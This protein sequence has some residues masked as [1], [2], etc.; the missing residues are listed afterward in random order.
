MIDHVFLQVKNISNGSSGYFTQCSV[1]NCSKCAWKIPGLTILCWF[2][3]EEEDDHDDDDDKQKQTQ[4]VN[5][6]NN[7]SNNNKLY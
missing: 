5:N 4:M 6:N 3:K 1:I 2:P 7:N